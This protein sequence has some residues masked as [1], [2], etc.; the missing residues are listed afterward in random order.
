MNT[1]TTIDT[2]DLDNVSGGLS[3]EIN[4]QNTP[5]GTIQG[6]FNSQQPPDADRQLRCYSQVAR[7]A[8]YLQSPNATIRQQQ[9]L[10][11]PLT[12]TR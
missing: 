5:V 8:G 11:G 10:C 7:Q 1:F 3:A 12:G 9:D 2:L 4:A 6:Q